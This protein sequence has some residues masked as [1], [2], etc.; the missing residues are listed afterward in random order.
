M[1][2]ILHI[3]TANA[4]SRSPHIYC[5]TVIVA[6]TYVSAETAVFERFTTE[7]LQ[8]LVD[9]GIKTT[10][11]RIGYVKTKMITPQL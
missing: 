5:H 2:I 8:R 9:C 1:Y 3:S 10:V 4:R 7:A 6:M 11:G